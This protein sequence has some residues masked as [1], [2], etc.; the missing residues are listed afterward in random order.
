MSVRENLTARELSDMA[1]K[2]I[3]ATDWPYFGPARL[4]QLL[5]DLTDRVA[6]LEAAIAAK[7]DVQT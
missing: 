3:H 4:S 7:G 6:K 2:W 1:P 5:A